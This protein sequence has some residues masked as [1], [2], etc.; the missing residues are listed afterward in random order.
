[1]ERSVTKIDA[2]FTQKRYAQFRG[3]STSDDYNRRVEEYYQDLVYLVNRARLSE[4]ELN[5]LYRR[6]ARE[7]ASYELMIQFLEERVSALEAVGNQLGFF[8]RQQIDTDRFNDKPLFNISA[9][10]RL[11]YD[12]Q[13]GLLTLPKVDTSSLSKLLFVNTEGESIVPPSLEMRVV[14]TPG[15]ADTPAAIIDQSQPELAVYRRPGSIWER[16]VIVDL[17]TLNGAEMT[18]YIKVPTDLFTTDR[19]NTIVIHPYPAFNTTIREISYTLAPSPILENTDGYTPINNSGS[20]AGEEAAIGWV[21]PGGWTAAYAGKDAAVAAGPKI[22][23]FPALPIT[24]L[25]IRLHQQEKVREDAK[26]IYSYGLSHLD[27]R[28]DKFLGQGKTI[29]RFDAPKNSVINN[30]LDVVPE[31]WNVP[32]AMMGDIFSFRTIW[33]TAYNSGEYTLEPVANSLRV[34]I[35]V[36]LKGEEGQYP[37]LSGL[38]VNADIAA[39]P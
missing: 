1:M 12:T 9:V 3:P 20:Y 28:Y 19:S 18:A 34:W 2:P 26:F 25:K 39:A 24:A 33:E 38:T 31:I 7:Q 29:I 21:A 30:V 36:T 14:G 5:E 32:R 4:V 23:H 35:E 16:N 27:L 10:D 11:S 17:P 15:T 37:A 22:Y 6:V 13:Y 8:S